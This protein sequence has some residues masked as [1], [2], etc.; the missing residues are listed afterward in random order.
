MIMSGHFQIHTA[1]GRAMS[2][3]EHQH[4]QQTS[5]NFELYYSAPF[6]AA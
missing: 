5:T 6:I 2:D 1:A 4:F 3:D